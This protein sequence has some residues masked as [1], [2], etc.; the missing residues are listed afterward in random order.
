MAEEKEFKRS[1]ICVI[2][3]PVWAHWDV[4]AND[5]EV[6]DRERETGRGGKR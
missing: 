2:F 6:R 1:E 4:S 5:S 3:P